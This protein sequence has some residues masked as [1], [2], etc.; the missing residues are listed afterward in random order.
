MGRKLDVDHLVGSNEIAKRLGFR[1]PQ[2]VHH[3]KNH[4]PTF[5][6]P[7]L[8]LGRD[9]AST[10]IWYWPDVE[11]WAM[12]TGRLPKSTSRSRSDPEDG[13]RVDDAQRPTAGPTAG[14]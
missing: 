6:E 12:R 10:H 7:V 8:A 1:H 14:Q 4:D 9:R 11:R 3:Y 5:P 2:L 13:E